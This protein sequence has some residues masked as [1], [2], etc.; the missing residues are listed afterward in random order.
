MALGATSATAP[1][2][3]TA[4]S[5]ADVQLGRVDECRRGGGH[6][7]GHAA[8]TNAGSR[9]DHRADAAGSADRSGDVR[10]HQSL[11]DAPRRR[12]VSADRQSVRPDRPAWNDVRAD[13][14][15]RCC[16]VDDEWSCGW[17]ARPFCLGARHASPR[18]ER[19]LGRQH[20]RRRQVIRSPRRLG[21]GRL[22]RAAD[23][24]LRRSV[25][26]GR[27]LGPR[28]WLADWLVA[29]R[30]GLVRVGT[31][32]VAAAGTPSRGSR[33]RPR[34]DGQSL[35]RQ[36]HCAPRRSGSSVGRHP[37]SA[38][39]RLVSDS[40]TRLSW[41]SA[42]SISRRTCGSSPGHRSSAWPVSSGAAG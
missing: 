9:T 8:G 18:T 28:R 20:H 39:S 42:A 3:V 4:A 10:Q 26:G 37:C 32:H 35:A 23:G 17:G 31:H 13:G 21:H 33:G 19:A 15:A 16:R 1:G 7:A 5:R 41:R 34:D 2:D 36:P 38:W 22:L 11:G 40:S 25:H 14:L 6:H 12:C 30:G 24:V 29:R 27:H